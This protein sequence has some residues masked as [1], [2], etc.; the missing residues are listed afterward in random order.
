MP[1]ARTRF[2]EVVDV[3]EAFAEA[4]PL[5]RRQRRRHRQVD[6]DPAVG[7]RIVGRGGDGPRGSEGHDDRVSP[8]D[9]R[10]AR[11]ERHG[12]RAEIGGHLAR[13]RRVSGCQVHAGAAGEQA[14]RGRPAHRPGP[15]DQHP[16]IGEAVE[17]GR[18]APDRPVSQGA[19]GPIR[20]RRAPRSPESPGA[21]R[22]I[23][24]RAEV[25]VQRS[26][27]AGVGHRGPQLV[28][29]LVL[30]DDRRLE[31]DRQADDVSSGPFAVDALHARPEQRP[32]IGRPHGTLPER[33]HLHPMAGGQDDAARQ[34]T[35]ARR[36]REDAGASRGID[37]RRGGDEGLDPH[38]QVG[39]HAIGS[40]DR[41][42][43]SGPTRPDAVARHRGD[44]ESIEGP[45]RVRV[46]RGD[47]RAIEPAALGDRPDLGEERPS[48]RE[49][50]L[51]RVTH[52]QA[53]RRAAPAVLDGDR[54]GLG[55]VV[56]AG[57][58]FVG[59]EV[60]DE[61]PG[62]PSTERPERVAIR[63]GQRRQPGGVPGNG[64]GTAT[65]RAGQAGGRQ[66]AGGQL[67]P[68]R[69]IDRQQALERGAAEPTVTAGRGERLETT[70]IGPA[71]DGRGRDAEEAAGIAEAE[72]LRTGGSGSGPWRHQKST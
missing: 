13:A 34:R 44:E 41:G 70:R 16:A 32:P 18:D 4:G 63:L 57:F 68:A 54:R 2:G 22:C 9:E 31:P 50:A 17:R 27:G 53:E 15:D 56:G 45:V 59:V 26:A 8:V 14:D 67:R 66:A 33:E 65:V 1:I 64:G 58:G 60:G 12:R 43:R 3:D 23:E 35:D 36:V 51:D 37:G 29:D 11:I 19:V 42:R 52:R 6:D 55:E 25:R 39:L 40:S 38:V 21:Q 48:E 30:A 62:Q 7:E 71:T 69:P 10:S 28:E 20:L 61:L 47:L 46:Q 5:V 24:E 49:E 72:P